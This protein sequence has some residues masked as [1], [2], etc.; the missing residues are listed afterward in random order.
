MAEIIFQSK[1]ESHRFYQHLLKYIPISSDEDTILLLEDR[2]IVKIADGFIS[3]D[4]VNKL[5]TAFYDFITNIK[6]DDWLKEIIK[7]HYYFQDIE[8]QQQIMEIIYSILEGERADLAV[9][10][11]E[12]TEGSA[13]IMTAIHHIIKENVSFS[14]DALLKFRLRPYIQSLEGYVEIAIDEYKMEQE[15]QMFVQM[16]RDFLINR[17]PKI[18]TLHLLVD[19]EITFYNEQFVEMKR[20][21]L[22]RLID[23]K[24][25]V[26]HPVYVDS[27]SI[28]PLLSLAPTTIYIY[29]NDPDEPLIR[30]I[31]NIFEERVTIK[32]FAAL[33]E[34]KKGITENQSSEN[35]G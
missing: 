5:K 14:F 33:R 12:T 32:T 7:N 26:N 28:A 34:R 22:I 8:E 18:G 21:E 10:V 9:F 24:L 23:R 4:Q 17:E 16:L 29:T 2:H 20:A 31:A 13:G 35:H 27:A 15:Y 25:L 6:R 19:N 30:T 11:K 1:M 3:S